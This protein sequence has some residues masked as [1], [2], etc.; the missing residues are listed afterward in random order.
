MF[1]IDYQTKQHKKWKTN[2]F[3]SAISAA[4]DVPTFVQLGQTPHPL[5]PTTT[6]MPISAASDP[7]THICVVGINVQLMER[8]YLYINF[9]NLQNAFQILGAVLRLQTCYRWYMSILLSEIWAKLNLGSLILNT[10]E[11]ITFFCLGGKKAM[12]YSSTNLVTKLLECSRIYV[13]SFK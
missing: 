13:F 10:G 12:F 5:P 9:F 1:W 6:L 11:F 2:A 4:S 7:P 3:P 8:E